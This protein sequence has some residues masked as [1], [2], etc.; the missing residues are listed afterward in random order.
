M[1]HD[2]KHEFP[3]PYCKMMCIVLEGYGCGKKTGCLHLCL[4]FEVCRVAR[5]PAVE[6]KATIGCIVVRWLRCVVRA[7]AAMNTL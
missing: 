7:R 5:P 2:P 1:A 3:I 4:K 6:L